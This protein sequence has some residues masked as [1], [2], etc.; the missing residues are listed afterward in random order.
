MIQERIYKKDIQRPIN[1]VIKA[2]HYCPVKV[3]K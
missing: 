3:N 1:G 2:D